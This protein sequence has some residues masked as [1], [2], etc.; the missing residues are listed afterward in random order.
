MIANNVL[1]WLMVPALV[2]GSARDSLHNVVVAGTACGVTDVVGDP[3]LDPER[4]A[5]GRLGA[6]DRPGRPRAR[7]AAR[8]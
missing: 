8:H 2:C 6:R 7:A 3:L 5:D 4:P 1:A